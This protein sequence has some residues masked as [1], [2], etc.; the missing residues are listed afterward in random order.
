M[1]QLT[2]AALETALNGSDTNRKFFQVMKSVQN[3]TTSQFLVLALCYASSRPSVKTGTT[4]WC[5]TTD[6][7]GTT[8]QRDAV[9]TAMAN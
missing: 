8:T 7:N 2:A 6:A 9:Y 4:R 5:T 3:G 1:A